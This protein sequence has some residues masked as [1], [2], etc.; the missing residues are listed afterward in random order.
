MSEILK[1][2]HH[3]SITNK[4]M[5]VEAHISKILI[6]AYCSRDHQKKQIDEETITLMIKEITKG[7]I[8]ENLE[9]K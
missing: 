2:I 9:K 5:N 7:F 8:S 6:K 4:E 1:L 3:N